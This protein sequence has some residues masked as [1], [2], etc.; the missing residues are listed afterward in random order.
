MTRAMA[1]SQCRTFGEAKDR[2]ANRE[3]RILPSTDSREQPVRSRSDGL[4]EIHQEDRPEGMMRR[5]SVFVAQV[6]HQTAFDFIASLRFKGIVLETLAKVVWKNGHSSH[7]KYL[8]SGSVDDASGAVER[9]KWSETTSGQS[10]LTF[11]K[12][13]PDG[14]F[15]D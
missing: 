3:G 4:V 6:M 12:S 2:L 10:R 15:R 1:V 11:L 8:R 14:F 5:A 9:A 13:L 7:L